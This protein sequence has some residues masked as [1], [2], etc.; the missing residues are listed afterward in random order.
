VKITGAGPFPIN[1]NTLQ[2]GVG[3]LAGGT[4]T[5]VGTFSSNS[6]ISGSLIANNAT[7]NGCGTIN[8]TAGWSAKWVSTAQGTDIDRSS[9]KSPVA[10]MQIL[11]RTEK[12][13]SSGGLKS[14]EP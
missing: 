5:T 12:Q 6:S 3:G 2:I 13:N 7:I 4:F 9:L 10:D 8:G 11:S 14:V 1:G